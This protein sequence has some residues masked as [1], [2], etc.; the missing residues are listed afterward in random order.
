MQRRHSTHRWRRNVGL[1]VG[2][3]LGFEAG[4]LD[5]PSPLAAMRPTFRPVKLVVENW[6]GLGKE[7][8]GGWEDRTGPVSPPLPPPRGARCD[9][10][11]AGGF[12][13]AAASIT[14]APLPEKPSAPVRCFATASDCMV[15]SRVRG[16]HKKRISSWSAAWRMLNPSAAYVDLRCRCPSCRSGASWRLGRS[17]KYSGSFLVPD[18]KVQSVVQDL[19]AVGSSAKSSILPPART[20][21]TAT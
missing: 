20:H 5:D 6:R 18:W 2:L 15:S 9:S 8:K 11:P 19:G 7:A 10:T 3:A 14:P 4:R 12:G 17:M 16:S 1:G 21:S 13:P